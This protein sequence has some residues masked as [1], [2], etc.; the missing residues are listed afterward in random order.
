MATNQR[1]IPGD[2]RYLNSGS[3][4]STRLQRLLLSYNELGPAG[5]CDVL[6]SLPSS[7]HHLDMSS[8]AGDKRSQEVADHFKAYLDRVRRKQHGN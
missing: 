4:A 1:N 7:V 3:T 5:I 8:T 6:N 2:L